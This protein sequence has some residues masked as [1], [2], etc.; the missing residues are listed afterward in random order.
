ME[1]RER[2]FVLSSGLKASSLEYICGTPAS[3]A[4]SETKGYI[5]LHGWLDNAASFSNIAPSI[6]SQTG[7]HLVCLDLIGHGKSDALE[8]DQ[9]YYPWEFALMVLDVADSLGW[10]KFNIMGHRY[11]A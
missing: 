5:V 9:I 4:D 3:S 2:E 10:E 8:K 7:A 6:S 11:V 1:I